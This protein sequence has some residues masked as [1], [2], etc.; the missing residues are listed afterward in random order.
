MAQFNTKNQSS[1]VSRRWFTDIDINMSL[2]PESNDLVLKYDLNAIKRSLRN[3]L[4]TNHYE[5]PFKPSFG[6][7]IRAMLF[8]L[9]SNETKVIKRRII[10]SITKAEPRVIVD[11]I[12]ASIQGTSLNLTLL[13]GIVNNKGRHQL[14]VIVERVR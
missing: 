8:E 2:H 3:I 9:A 5:R 12:N 7:N 1:T 14:D 11:D 6:S 4:Q 10:D 13:F